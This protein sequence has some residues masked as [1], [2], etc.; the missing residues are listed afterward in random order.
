MVPEL[1]AFLAQTAAEPAQGAGG[2]DALLK[3]M[4]FP[5]L[6][7]VAIF[8]LLVW[9]PQS[10]DRKRHTQWLAAV[11]KGDEVVTQSGIIGTIHLVEDKVV[12]L[13]VGGGTKLRVLKSQV[14]SAWKQSEP[15]A[16]AKP[17]ARK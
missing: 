4:G 16:P 13:D 3:G 14:A 7:M 1:S 9:R 5:I 6:A 2:L 17:E 12:T 10:R 8:Y 15:V 11:K